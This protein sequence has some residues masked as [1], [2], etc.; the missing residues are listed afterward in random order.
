MATNNF[1]PDPS[2]DAFEPLMSYFDPQGVNRLESANISSYGFDGFIPTTVQNRTA[3]GIIPGMSIS[4]T[5]SALGQYFYKV[6]SN[7]IGD[8]EFADEPSGEILIE[9]LDNNQI[10]QSISASVSDIFS[11]SYEDWDGKDLGTTGWYLGNSGNA[12]FS[13]VAVRGRIEAT[14]GKVEDL[15]IGEAYYSILNIYGVENQSSSVTGDKGQFIMYVLPLEYSSTNSG[16]LLYSNDI[17]ELSGV[18]ASGWA[19]TFGSPL[20]ASSFFNIYNKIKILSASYSEFDFSLPYPVHKYHCEIVQ[21]GM[22]SDWNLGSLSASSGSF[23]FGAMNM[24]D[25]KTYSLANQ[26]T[27]EGFVFHQIGQGDTWDAHI[28]DF[29]DVSGRFRLGGGKLIF[30]GE[31]LSIDA[32]LSVGDLSASYT[33]YDFLSGSYVTAYKLSASGQTVISG[34]NITS[35]RIKSS[36]YNGPATGGGSFSTVGSQFNLDDGTIVS[37]QFR[38]DSSGNATFA[39]SLSAATGTFSGNLSAAGGTFAGSLSAATGTFAGTLSANS[40]TSGTLNAS[41]VSVTNLNADNITTGTIT[42]RTFRSSS[43]ITSTSGTGVYLDASG[44]VRFA[45]STGTLF[46]F[47]SSV[48]NLSGNTLKIGSQYTSGVL[49]G[50]VNFYTTAGGAIGSI[51]SANSNKT[52]TGLGDGITM[53]TT[54]DYFF[55]PAS[56]NSTRARYRGNG[57]EVYSQNTIR[58]MS[59]SGGS[60]GLRI[61]NN[62][63]GIQVS[64]GGNISVSGGTFTG[65]GISNLTSQSSGQGTH[66]LHWNSTGGAVTRS[67]SL[68]TG[69]SLE[70]KQDIEEFSVNNSWTKSVENVYTFVYKSDY[71]EDKENAKRQLGIIIDEVSEIPELEPLIFNVNDHKALD[72]TKIGVLLIPVINSLLEKVDTLEHRIVELESRLGKI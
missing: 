25:Y 21:S 28:P 35:G 70:L 56:G 36:G 37:K 7:N 11:V 39:G 3:S 51:S 50:S 48:F 38:I 53:G 40:I 47:D 65:D 9:Y 2:N 31:T 44:N 30:D 62:T 67:T 57:F 42:G 4:L 66:Y 45:T 59:I 8:R 58:L 63:G 20:S 5:G 13:N 14:S 12:I 29:L 1:N 41:I 61:E 71:E 32:A 52:W 43:G 26:D 46:S 60:G 17:V 69:S 22:I 23:T 68:P 34:G 49:Y 6:I 72:Y 55:V 16:K 18:S 15:V 27:I 19:Y 33:T 24:G 10:I 54:S 64:G